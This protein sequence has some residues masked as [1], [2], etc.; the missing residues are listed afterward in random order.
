MMAIGLHQSNKNAFT[1]CIIPATAKN[2]F[3]LETVLKDKD[4]KELGR[5]AQELIT[6][7]LANMS[8]SR[9]RNP[10]STKRPSSILNSNFGTLRKN[11]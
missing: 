11:D 9:R 4:G 5:P 1:F 2:L 3:T 6:I 7:V 8:P 10:N